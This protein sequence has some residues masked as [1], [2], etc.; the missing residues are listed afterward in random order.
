MNKLLSILACFCLL[1]SL[2]HLNAQTKTRYGKD[3]NRKQ[4]RTIT[5]YVLQQVKAQQNEY[6]RAFDA[7]AKLAKAS[8]EEKKAMGGSAETV[9]AVDKGFSYKSAAGLQAYYKAYQAAGGKAS[10]YEY[11]GFF[12]WSR[13]ATPRLQ[14]HKVN[15]DLIRMAVRKRWDPAKKTANGTK[16]GCDLRS[17]M[18][19]REAIAEELRNDPEFSTDEATLLKKEA[20]EIAKEVPL[21]KPG[22]IVNI[23][24]ARGREPCKRYRGAFRPISNNRIF[25]GKTQLNLWDIPE[26]LRARFDAK[27]NAEYRKKLQERHPLITKY[28]I[29]CEEEAD[30]RHDAAIGAQ[31]EANLKHG[32]VYINGT[33]HEPADMVDDILEQRKNLYKG[34]KGKGAGSSFKIEMGN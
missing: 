32:W 27:L 7:A 6:I 10:F 2:S 17:D 8:D 12:T 9:F 4:I 15:P 19:V 3:Y 29:K 23:A 5:Q 34:V 22:E 25:I 28:R 18:E 24:F 33:W 1:G 14:P 26:K 30:R 21:Y 20:E 16:H 11:E 31:M 13:G